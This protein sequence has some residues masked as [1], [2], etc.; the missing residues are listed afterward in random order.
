MKSIRRLRS[1][2]ATIG[3]VL[4]GLS[5]TPSAWALV[6]SGVNVPEQVTAGSDTLVL[7]GAGLRQKFVFHIYV[8]ALYTPKA[9][10]DPQAIITSTAP[11]I[12][13][14]TLMRDINSK[15]LVDAL[16]AGLKDNCTAQEL[17]AL[18]PSLKAFQAMMEHGGE[19][20][21]GD[22]VVLA[23]N[24]QGVSVSFKDKALGRVDDLRFAS[25]LL[26]VWLGDT[27]A[28]E[29]LKSALLGQK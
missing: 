21:A 24:A 2:A 6:V 19:G 25:A 23:F 5:I 4:I 8:A 10:H 13:H 14:L 17:E 11:R 18:A 22:P 16:N 3:F 15:A 27:P 7:N 20:T 26:R 29:S 28:Q 9:T 12:L 1:L